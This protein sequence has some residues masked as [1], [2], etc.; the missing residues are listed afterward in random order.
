MLEETKKLGKKAEKIEKDVEILKQDVGE[1]KQDV[2]G[3]KQDVAVLKQDVA[4]LK[5]DVAILKQDM[6]YLKGEFGRFKGKEFERTVREKYYAYFGKLLRK[7][8]LVSLEE[9]STLLDEA[10]DKKLITEEQK[11]SVFQL[12]LIV[13]GELKHT[14]KEVYLAV[15]V[16]YSLYEKD[17]ERALERSNILATIFK[18][19]VIPVVV[20]VEVKKELEKKAEESGVLLIKTDF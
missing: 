3:L 10:E 14:K 2:S 4:I 15:E 18:K 13:S 17:I 9:I 8:K 1:L 16:S 5:Q 11:L 20:A 12:D 6:A 19:E 7:S